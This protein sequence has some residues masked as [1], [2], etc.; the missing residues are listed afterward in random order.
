MRSLIGKESVAI[1]LEINDISLLTIS[2]DRRCVKQSMVDMPLKTQSQ[3]NRF[4]L[5]ACAYALMVL[6]GISTILCLGLGKLGLFVFFGGFGYS[7]AD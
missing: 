2:I 7:V 3:W 6:S 1:G 4:I 5:Y